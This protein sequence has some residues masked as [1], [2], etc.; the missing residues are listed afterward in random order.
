[1]L[2][3]VEPLRNELDRLQQKADSNKNK[4]AQVNKLISDLE[5]SIALYKEEY[6]QLI[7]QAQALKSSAQSVE[8]KV[9][10][11]IDI[12]SLTKMDTVLFIF[13]QFFKTILSQFMSL[14]VSVLQAW[15]KNVEF[16]KLPPRKCGYL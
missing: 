2:N 10:N 8:V 15:K 4:Q 3:R 9:C 16:R 12:F 14:T 13:S 7:S 6:A 5:T 11:R 1:M